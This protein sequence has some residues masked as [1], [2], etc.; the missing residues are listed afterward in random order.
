M[1]KISILGYCRAALNNRYVPSIVG[2]V[3]LLAAIGKLV[4][5]LIFPRSVPKFDQ[6]L[7]MIMGRQLIAVA[8]MMDCLLFILLCGRLFERK[9]YAIVGYLTTLVMLIYH[10]A[11]VIGG[12][13]TCG[14]AGRWEILSPTQEAGLDFLLLL[15]CLIAHAICASWLR[16][17]GTSQNVLKTA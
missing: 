11:A 10:G 14:C 12:R 8:I 15:A 13:A 2:W 17:R 1:S 3:F 16:Q 7:P 5:A 6:V 9:L 4:S